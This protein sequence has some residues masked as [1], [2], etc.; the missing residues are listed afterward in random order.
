VDPDD[1]QVEFHTAT[2]R[3]EKASDFKIQYKAKKATESTH[4]ELLTAS[5]KIKD[6]GGGKYF[7]AVNL[8]NIISNRTS[9]WKIAKISNRLPQPT[10][11]W[12]F[13][14]DGEVRNEM[15]SN[16]ILQW[17]PKIVQRESLNFKSMG[18]GRRS[19]SSQ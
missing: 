11:E 1:Q 14:Y 18:I 3:L 15:N 8:F 2:L 6:A 12:H 5:E 7:S 13:K 19:P 16:L 17:F 10:S 4:I 9:K